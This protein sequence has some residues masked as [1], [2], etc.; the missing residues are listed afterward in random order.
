MK[1]MYAVLGVALLSLFAVSSANAEGP[2]HW[3]VRHA[4]NAVV[5]TG[6]TL[7]NVSRTAARTVDH[8][9]VKPIREAL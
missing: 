7:A 8:H 4:T 3:T 2:L 1:K 6:H 9:V 5:E